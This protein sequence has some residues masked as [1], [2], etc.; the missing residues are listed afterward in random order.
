[1]AQPVAI[2]AELV[3]PAS[4]ITEREASRTVSGMTYTRVT[5]Q[6]P[7][8]EPTRATGPY[9]RPT[10]VSQAPESSRYTVLT[11]EGERYIGQ[12][13]FTRYTIDPVTDS[14]FDANKR[15]DKESL[16]WW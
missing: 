9:Q 7:V 13:K 15:E 8:Y 10:Y 1:M 14:K 5:T 11:L 2:H 16:R 3:S 12:N 4:I 6:E